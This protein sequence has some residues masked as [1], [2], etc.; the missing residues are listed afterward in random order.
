MIRRRQG[1]TPNRG[2]ATAGGNEGDRQRLLKREPFKTLDAPQ[3]PKR[4]VVA[5]HKQMLAV[6]DGIA[7]LRI[8][9][10]ISAP[11]QNLPSFEYRHAA[12]LFSERRRG[13]KAG[14]AA[15]DHND[16]AH[17]SSS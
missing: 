5:A 8:R 4:L 3:K 16:I 11:A 9:E 13:R 7:H 6:V 1:P 17:V 15:S 12:S 10:G 2:S 14:E